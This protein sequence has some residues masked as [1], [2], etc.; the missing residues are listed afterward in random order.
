DLKLKIEESQ[1]NNNLFKQNYEKARKEYEALRDKES[2]IKEKNLKIEYKYNLTKNKIDSLIE[3]E[4]QVIIDILDRYNINI[5]K[6][7]IDKNENNNYS[8]DG[9]KK[10]KEDL[11]KLGYF[12]PDSIIE[13]ESISKEIEFLT[14]QQNDLLKSKEDIL[15]IIN[16]LD[17]KMTSMFIESLENINKKF[18][19]IFTVLFN[20]GTASLIL[21]SDDIL[22]AG[23]D[24]V[25]EPPGKKL[26]NLNLLS[27][28]ERSLTAVALLF[29]IFETRPSPFC[30]LDEIDAA[31]DEANIYRYTNYLKDI[32]E[33]TQIIMITHRKST[34]EIADALYGVSMEEKGISKT[35]VL[36]LEK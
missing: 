22:N 23:I 6:Y 3:K 30:I 26:Q 8:K 28:G 34:M 4:N 10:L 16:E 18:E 21:N 13:Y 15:K 1:K 33:K 29:A 19:R 31:L 17:E 5:V 32:S 12:S 24:I 11:K 2:E 25:A 7:N 20:G 14:N 27:G 9:L 35:I 36:N